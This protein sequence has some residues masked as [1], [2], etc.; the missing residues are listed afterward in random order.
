[1]LSSHQ[2]FF[3]CYMHSIAT[4]TLLESIGNRY[5]GSTL[6]ILQDCCHLNLKFEHRPLDCSINKKQYYNKAHVITLSSH[7]ATILS[8]LFLVL[9]TALL[10]DHREQTYPIDCKQTILNF[11]V[12]R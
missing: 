3:L 6:E 9:T 12:N 5:Y 11:L 8:K 1:M 7:I 10:L 2:S 4:S